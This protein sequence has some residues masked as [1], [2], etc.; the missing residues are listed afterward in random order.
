MA[1]VAGW[2][3][4]RTLSPVSWGRGEDFVFLVP[5]LEFPCRPLRLR[6]IRG[7]PCQ[8]VACNWQAQAGYRLLQQVSIGDGDSTQHCADD[9]KEALVGA[10]EEQI[11]ERGLAVDPLFRCAV[12][13]AV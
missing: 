1:V 7:H 12:N 2:Y 4:P 9:A 10:A 3:S 11:A 13:T 5:E 6:F 8:S